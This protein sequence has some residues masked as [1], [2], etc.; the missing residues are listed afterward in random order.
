[1]EILKG[2]AL[3][4]AIKTIRTKG[5]ELDALI[6]QA[7][8]SAAVAVEEYGNVGYCNALYHA[9]PKGARHKALVLWLTLYAG[10]QP[11]TAKDKEQKPFVFDKGGCVDVEGGT[12]QPW[13]E[14]A[15][16]PE[17]D[18]V[19]DVLSL[20]RTVIRRAR[21]PKD[22]VEVRNLGI[23]STLDSVVAEYAKK[24]PLD[25]IIVEG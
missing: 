3:I 16:S 24:D 22:G 5:A 20:V 4:S 18:S 19:L 21:S 8:I 15:P 6:Q 2:Q 17:P 11:N 7:A 23:L 9:L 13:Y 10:V 14:C 1:M 12:A 25:E